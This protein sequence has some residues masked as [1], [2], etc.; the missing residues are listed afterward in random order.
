MRGPRRRWWPVFRGRG[1]LGREWDGIVCAMTMPTF[2]DVDEALAKRDY[3]AALDM[4][5]S[6]EVVGEDACY[7]RDIQAAACAD[8]LPHHAAP[9]ARRADQCLEGC[10]HRRPV[11]RTLLPVRRPWSLSRCPVGSLPAVRRRHRQRLLLRGSPDRH[12]QPYPAARRAPDLHALVHAIHRAGWPRL[13]LHARLP[14]HL[15][16]LPHS[17]LERHRVSR[18]PSHLGRR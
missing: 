18:P 3:R 10:R 9:S 5:E 12:V 7:R 8:R 6:M 11:L 2:A 16:L 15:R 14:H 4:L 17:L 13:P 1:H